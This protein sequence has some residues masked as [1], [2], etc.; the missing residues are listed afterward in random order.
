MY[1]L[2]FLCKRTTTGLGTRALY[3]SDVLHHSL[4]IIADDLV[5][6]ALVPIGSRTALAILLTVHRLRLVA[7]P[8]FLVATA[9]STDSPYR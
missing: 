3:Q 9:E 5:A 2:F 8:P 1:P 7:R 6:L 4:L